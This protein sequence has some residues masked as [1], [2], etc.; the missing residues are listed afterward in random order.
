M[1]FERVRQI[2]CDQ[3]DLDYDEVSL[4]SKII[5]EL[6]ADSLDIIDLGLSLQEEFE[7]EIPEDELENIQTVED[8]VAYIE[9]NAVL[10]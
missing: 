4:T 1:I 5:D 10:E 9:D 6:D 2:I 8:I 3:L 7:V